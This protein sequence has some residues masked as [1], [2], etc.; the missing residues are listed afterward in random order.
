MIIIRIALIG[1]E[2]TGKSTLAEAL[3]KYYKTVLVKEYAR[4]YLISINRKYI[5]DDLIVIAKEQVKQ[6]QQLIPK[7]TKFI[8]ID[9]ELI[10]SKVW[11]EDVFKI[12]PEWISENIVKQK[13]D[14]YLLTSPDFPWEEDS[15]RENPH[16]REFFFDW[17]ERE[18]KNINANYVIIKG[19]GDARLKNCI[20][21]IESFQKPV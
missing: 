1:P 3:A 5:L 18:L 9:S 17:Y 19:V 11:C 13:Y 16:R 15:L 12:C 10:I 4:E 6:E 2:S 14:L 21:V 8:F 20:D 7:A